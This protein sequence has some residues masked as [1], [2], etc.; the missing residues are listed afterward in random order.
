MP[1]FA[2]REALQVVESDASGPKDAPVKFGM[3][4]GKHIRFVLAGD[5]HG[6]RLVAARPGLERGRAWTSAPE[7]TLHHRPRVPRRDARNAWICK[8]RIL[9]T[10]IS[11]VSRARELL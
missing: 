1:C 4:G 2:V 10:E 8:Q 9:F 7:R 3:P 11:C 5:D 6:P